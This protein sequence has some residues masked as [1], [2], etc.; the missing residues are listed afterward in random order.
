[1]FKI[2]AAATADVPDL[3]RIHVEGWRGAYSG[4]VPQDHLDGLRVEDK[5]AQWQRWLAEGTTALI[6]RDG[7]G[8]PAGFVSFG[9]LRTPPPG[10]S[11]IRPVYSGEIYALYLMPQF[12]R[13]GL[14]RH[15]MRDGA[16]GLRAMK[17]KSLCLWVMEGNKRAVAFYKAL[18]GQRCGTKQ[19][20]VGG[21]VLPEIAYGWRD[22]AG[23]IGES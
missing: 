7:A 21:R 5:K 4:L 11:P 2:L 8:A 22:T 14:G 12:W 15:L 20:E 19:I 17:H 18:G 13:Q 3:A 1:M 16:L 10:L 23:L 6:A 9:R